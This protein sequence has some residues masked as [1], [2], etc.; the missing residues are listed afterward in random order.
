MD[1]TKLLSLVDEAMARRGMKDDPAVRKFLYVSA[2]AMYPAL[3]LM[4][5]FKPVRFKK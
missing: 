3:K 1:K 2:R 4:D 5:M